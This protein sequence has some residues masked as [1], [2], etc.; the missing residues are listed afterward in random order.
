MVFFKLKTSRCVLPCHK[1]VCTTRRHKCLLTV[2]SYY[3][4]NGDR[5]RPIFRSSSGQYS[6]K[7]KISLE[8]IFH[9]KG[10]MEKYVNNGLEM[11]LIWV[12]THRHCVYNN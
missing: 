7:I 4:F 12:E 11:T 3:K 2:G 10:A 1:W 8:I 6:R 9:I 5:F